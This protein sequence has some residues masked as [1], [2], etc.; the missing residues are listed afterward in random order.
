MPPSHS[1]LKEAVR[2]LRNPA[3]VCFAWFGLTA[4]VALLAVPAIFSAGSAPRP[5]ALDV[6]RSV[7]GFLSRAEFVFL[8]VLL[9]LVRVTGQARQWWAI[10]TFLAL[11]MIAQGTWLV[12]ELS[13]RT[14]MILS[15]SEPPPSI[16]HAAYSTST[17]V[18]LVLLF[19]MGAGLMV[20]TSDRR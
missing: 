4:G 10:S 6:A 13:A 17:L 9:I 14:D 16:A 11:I 7:F 15:G 3:W 1:R 5:I 19:I 2:L 12:P 8:I 18:K 20:G